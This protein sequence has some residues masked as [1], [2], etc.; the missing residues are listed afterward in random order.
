VFPVLFPVSFSVSFSVAETAE[1][2]VAALRDLRRKSFKTQLHFF[3]TTLTISLSLCIYASHLSPFPCQRLPKPFTEA[4][5]VRV[6]N[7]V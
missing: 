7:V 1:L 5:K 4:E 3:K 2:A 6:N